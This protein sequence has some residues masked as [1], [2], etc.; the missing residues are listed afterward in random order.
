VPDHPVFARFYDRLLARTER[1]GLSEMRG[2][3]LGSA[4][5]R[6]LE[7]GAGT[8]GNLEHYTDAVTELVLAEPDPNMATLLRE[9]LEREGTPA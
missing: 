4:S 5:G 3:L 1:G 7:L 9:R 2:R 8:G 6:V